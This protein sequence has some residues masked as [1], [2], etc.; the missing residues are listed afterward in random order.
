MHK[1]FAVLFSL[2]ML[3]LACGTSSSGYRAMSA[4]QSLAATK[5]V[6]LAD[7]EA[8]FRQAA[9]S[10]VVGTSPYEFC[11]AEQYLFLARDMKGRGDT[12]A[13]NNYCA[14]SK[15]MSETSLRKSGAV[16]PDSSSLA[17]DRGSCESEFARLKDSYL[18]IDANRAIAVA[19]M[20]YARLKAALSAAEYEIQAMRY[21]QAGEVLGLAG[22]YLN[23]ILAQD[24]DGDGVADLFDGAPLAPEDKDGF[25]DADGIPDLDNDQD[26]VLDA[27]DAAPNVAE[28][29]NRWHDQDGAPDEYP[30]L[31][32][33]S[34]D[35]GSDVLSAESK[36]YLRGLALVLKEWPL[37]KLRIAGYPDS[38]GDPQGSFDLAQRRSTAV[39]DYLASV[40]VTSGQMEVAFSE[41]G[42]E[43]AGKSSVKLEFR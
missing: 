17:S 37:L 21:S 8:T 29:K 36:E 40:G 22:I 15:E 6:E 33:L 2:A 4:S 43:A 1:S 39:R 41:S 11:L 28:T 38:N 30:I 3:S 5:K 7:A 16:P 25:E 32:N 26:G 27:N 18:S 24:T 35:A 34:F 19:P 20:L 12:Q 31:E 14:L 23:A 10:G 9:L 42:A 13:M